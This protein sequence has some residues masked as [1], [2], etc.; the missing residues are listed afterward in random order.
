MCKQNEW[1]LGP[2]FVLESPVTGKV[3]VETTLSDCVCM[4]DLM[5]SCYT[6]VCNVQFESPEKINDLVRVSSELCDSR[7][8]KSKKS[9]ESTI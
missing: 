1:I 4:C 2:G 9:Q 5:K 6:I 8:Y 7:I 3:T